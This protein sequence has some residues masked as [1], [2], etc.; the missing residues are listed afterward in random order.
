[1]LCCTY[2]YEMIFRTQFLKIKHKLHIISG[3]APSTPNKN[4]GHAHGRKNTT[5]LAAGP[6]TFWFPSTNNTNSAVTKTLRWERKQCYDYRNE[7]ISRNRVKDFRKKKNIYIYNVCYG[8]YEWTAHKKKQRDHIVKSLFTSL[9]P[10]VI[11]EHWRPTCEI[12]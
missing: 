9:C 1:M 4:S 8:K 11:T 10:L 3:S 5:V 7:I 2:T 6:I 12:L